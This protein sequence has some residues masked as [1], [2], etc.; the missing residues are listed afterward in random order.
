MSIVFDKQFQF[1]FGLIKEGRYSEFV[2]SD[3][4]QFHFGLIKRKYGHTT[5]TV[6]NYFNSTLV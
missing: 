2:T 3:A 6:L 4:F 1:H 5:K